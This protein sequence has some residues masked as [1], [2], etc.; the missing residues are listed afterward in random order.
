MATAVVITTVRPGIGLMR[1]DS[2]SYLPLLDEA[3]PE[4]D[5]FLIYAPSPS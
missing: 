1:P 2:E 5:L 4:I 3:S